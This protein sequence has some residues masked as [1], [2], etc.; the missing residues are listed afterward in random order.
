MKTKLEEREEMRMNSK[1]KHGRCL[2]ESGERKD[3]VEE[4][5]REE[6]RG[7]IK[8]LRR[9]QELLVENKKSATDRS[10]KKSMMGKYRRMRRGKL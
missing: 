3:E 5:R 10:E 9:N 2:R 6:C 7:I 8:D 4:E 1:R